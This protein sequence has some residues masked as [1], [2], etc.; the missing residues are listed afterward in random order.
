MEFVV[1][2]SWLMFSLTHC[3]LI[4]KY[5]CQQ[6]ESSLVQVMACCQFDTKT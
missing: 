5:V 2:W 3:G 1:I 6:I 4:I